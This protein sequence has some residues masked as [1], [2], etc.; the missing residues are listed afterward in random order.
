MT[1]SSPTTP[2][3][4]KPPFRWRRACLAPWFDQ[5]FAVAPGRVE[6]LESSDTWMRRITKRSS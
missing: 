3:G 2:T 5:G 1:G 4:G 6:L